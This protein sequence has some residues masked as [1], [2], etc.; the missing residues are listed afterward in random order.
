MES[1]YKVLQNSYVFIT[2]KSHDSQG[3]VTWHS[4]DGQMYISANSNA[5]TPLLFD[6]G[7]QTAG[8]L[9]HTNGEYYLNATSCSQRGSCAGECRCND[10]PRQVATDED[11]DTDSLFG[12]LAKGAAEM[13]KK[14]AA[15]A[16]AATAKAGA[17]AKKGI[18]AASAAV[19]KRIE[20]AKAGVEAYNQKH[21]ELSAA[22]HSPADVHKSIKA[23]LEHLQKC[24]RDA[25]KALEDLKDILKETDMSTE[26]QRDL[27]KLEQELQQIVSEV[28]Q[29][30]SFHK[31]KE[32]V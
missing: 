19:K 27:T 30:L 10:C 25:N 21:A 1:D 8:T 2:A 20:A 22:G 31:E 32:S 15:S 17:A 13:A 3:T 14:G 24:I 18:A 23:H 6:P 9:V 7:Y 4:K 29:L 11:I 12:N 16:K 5:N 26:E 28:A